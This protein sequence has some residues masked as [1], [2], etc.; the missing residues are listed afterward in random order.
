MPLYQV[1]KIYTRCKTKNTN[2]LASPI[3]TDWQLDFMQYQRYNC[4]LGYETCAKK[5]INDKF[6]EKAEN[7]RN[8]TIL[9]PRT[10]QKNQ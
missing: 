6:Y 4:Q 10:L 9:Y 2:Q 7:T 8:L 3:A 5:L 1:N